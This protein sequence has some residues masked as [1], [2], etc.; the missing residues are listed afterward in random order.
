MMDWI[1]GA[2]GG[3]KA[4]TDITQ[5]MLTLKTDA[6]VTT[7]VVELNG[8]LLGLQSQLNSAHADQTTLT[9][10]I[11]ELEAE[12]AQFKRWEQEKERYQLHQTEAGGLV[13]RIKP[14]VQGTE[15]LHYICA[16]CYQKAVKTILQPGDE[17]YYTVLK[18]HPCG[19]SVR[20]KSIDLGA[21]VVVSTGRR[22]DWD[23]Y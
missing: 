18:C 16:D 14:E 9:R 11:G 21:P 8:V 6:A 19:S 13:Y 3:I 12:I 17:G 5:S 1:A 2:Y 20:V 22:I 15:P 7:K 10:R 23:G 4:A